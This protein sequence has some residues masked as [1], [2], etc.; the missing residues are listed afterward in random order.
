[1]RQVWRYGKRKRDVREEKGLRERRR[2]DTTEMGCKG[3]GREERSHWG[4][5]DR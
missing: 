4:V 3:A 2:D 1:M 5:G